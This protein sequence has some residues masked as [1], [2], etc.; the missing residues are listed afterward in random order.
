MIWKWRISVRQR[1]MLL[2]LWTCTEDLKATSINLVQFWPC[3]CHAT[4]CSSNTRN[5]LDTKIPS[6]TP[7]S[8]HSIR[9]E[10]TGNLDPR[11]SHLQGAVR[12]ETMGTR[13]RYRWKSDS[14]SVNF[15]GRLNNTFPKLTKNKSHN[16]FFKKNS[17]A[18][19]GIADL[20]EEKRKI[21]DLTRFG[22]INSRKL[23]I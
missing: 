3:L 8:L 20:W 7:G 19:F 14:T 16:N 12:W 1:Q 2:K 10:D 13:F 9:G 11:V 22:W 18:S 5:W 4:L 17:G 15:P 21:I 23:P 6:S